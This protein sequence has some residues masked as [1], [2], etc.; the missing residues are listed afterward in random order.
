MTPGEKVSLWEARQMMI[1][2]WRLSMS[3]PSRIATHRYEYQDLCEWLCAYEQVSL[4][5]YKIGLVLSVEGIYA[6]QDKTGTRYLYL[7]PTNPLGHD[8]HINPLRCELQ[9]AV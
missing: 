1:K 7:S 5:H 2:H 3:G 4:S 9:Q 8:A 6:K